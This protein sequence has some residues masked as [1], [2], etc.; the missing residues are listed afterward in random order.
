[1][2]GHTENLF[3]SRKKSRK[4]LT[5]F[6][7]DEEFVNYVNTGAVFPV[8]FHKPGAPVGR[9]GV[10]PDATRLRVVKSRPD[11]FIADGR[12]TIPA[13]E[14]FVRALHARMLWVQ[15]D[16]S[17]PD[18]VSICWDPRF[19]RARLPSGFAAGAT[20]SIVALL[21]LLTLLLPLAGANGVTPIPPNAASTPA[22]QAIAATSPGESAYVESFLLSQKLVPQSVL[23]CAGACRDLTT[24]FANVSVPTNYLGSGSIIEGAGNYWIN[25]TSGCGGSCPAYSLTCNSVS[26]NPT[27]GQ[28][29]CYASAVNFN[30]A[31]VTTVPQYNVTRLV[32]YAI[33]EA[34]SWIGSYSGASLTSSVTSFKPDVFTFGAPGKLLGYDVLAISWAVPMPSGTFVASKTT[35]EFLNTSTFLTGGSQFLLGSQWILIQWARLP[36]PSCVTCDV[37]YSH[38]EVQN[39]LFNLYYAIPPPT[40]GNGIL[41]PPSVNSTI[42]PGIIPGQIPGFAP[43]V[44]VLS[45]PQQTSPNNWSE[46][47]AWL[48]YNWYVSVSG[49]EVVS[50]WFVKASNVTLSINGVPLPKTSYTVSKTTLY[51]YPGTVSVVNGTYVALGVTF[52]YSPSFDPLAPVGVVDGLPVT[53]GGVIVALAVVATILLGYREITDPEFRKSGKASAA[54]GSLMMG[55]FALV[56][57]YL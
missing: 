16:V 48:N 40:A 24:G 15:Y 32:T 14:D 39:Y 25:V 35:V 27:A 54:L 49:F 12:A 11:R 10:F 44:L 34:A 38:A 56:V 52:H 31:Q 7:S 6:A 9:D 4:A 19:R 33:P 45:T 28:S 36:V 20:A 53:P 50:S 46:V 8:G 43:I 22:R 23:A 18:S 47:L 1:M 17:H 29:P 42:P 57:L 41:P 13:P 37:P 51:V 30:G 21:F 26:F 55:L 2:P 3:P 5:P